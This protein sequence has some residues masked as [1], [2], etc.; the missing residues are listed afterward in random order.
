M[1]NPIVHFE[2]N[3]ADGPK[4]REF[5]GSLFDWKLNDHPEMHYTIVETGEGNI[6]GGIGTSGQANYVTVY[7]QVPDLQATLTQAEQLGGKT[8]MPPMHVMDGVDI[9]LFTDPEGHVIGIIKG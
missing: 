7:V 9:A 6:G 5:Y 2:I 1:G 8:V 3:G 4:L